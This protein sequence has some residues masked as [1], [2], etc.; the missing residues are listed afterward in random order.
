LCNNFQKCACSS[1]DASDGGFWGGFGKLADDVNW[2]HMM[3]NIRKL[4]NIDTLIQFIFIRIILN[5]CFEIL[6]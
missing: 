5:K 2:I 1:G 3:E 4:T 6:K